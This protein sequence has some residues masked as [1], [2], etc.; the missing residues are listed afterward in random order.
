[1][2]E[3]LPPLSAVLLERQGSAGSTQNAHTPLVSPEHSAQSAP[4]AGEHGPP[5][6]GGGSPL[7]SGA[8]TSLSSDHLRRRLQ[9]LSIAE[10]G[11][12]FDGV[13]SLT[14]DGSPHLKP[15]LV[16]SPESP[17]M[18]NVVVH[19]MHS[20]GTFFQD[21]KQ[22]TAAVRKWHVDRWF[23]VRDS[24]RFVVCVLP[25]TRSV[26]A[27]SVACFPPRRSSPSCRGS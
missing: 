1:L 26:G 7:G 13:T 3:P 15:L 27:P 5:I 10:L 12:A 22:S 16:Q 24:R 4:S 14:S 17:A 25:R 19:A 9:V 20:A 6:P 11:A 2:H 8:G 18:R 23:R 21:S